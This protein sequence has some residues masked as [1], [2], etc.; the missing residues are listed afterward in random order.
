M[1]K[2]AFRAGFPG[3]EASRTVIFPLVVEIWQRSAPGRGPGF[4]QSRE[5][6]IPQDLGHDFI[7]GTHGHIRP[8][9]AT[10]PFRQQ[11]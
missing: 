6:N 2:I 8:R 7:H 4:D 11:R 9:Q 3:Q 1:R 10:E 5:G